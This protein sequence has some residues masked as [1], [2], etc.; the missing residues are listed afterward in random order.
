MPEREIHT[1]P[2]LLCRLWNPMFP[3]VI[4]F[5]SHHQQISVARHIFNGRARGPGSLLAADAEFLCLCPFWLN[6]RWRLP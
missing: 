3:L 6:V 5:A 4:G 1:L 2:N